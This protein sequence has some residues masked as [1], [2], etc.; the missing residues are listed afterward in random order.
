[1]E[2]TKLTLQTESPFRPKDILDSEDKG[3][4]HPYNKHGYDGDPLLS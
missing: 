4:Y 3:R 2:S 1:M